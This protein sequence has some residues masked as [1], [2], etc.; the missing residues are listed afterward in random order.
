MKEKETQAANVE[1]VHRC[2]RMR[3]KGCGSC[4]CKFEPFDQINEH[5]VCRRSQRSRELKRVARRAVQC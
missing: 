4:G 3:E 1:S 5:H 2:Y